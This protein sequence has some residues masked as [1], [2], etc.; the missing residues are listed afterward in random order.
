VGIEA[1]IRQILGPGTP[2]AVIEKLAKGG[3]E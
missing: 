3:K 1:A 2:A